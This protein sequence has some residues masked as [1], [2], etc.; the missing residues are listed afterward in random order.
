MTRGMARQAVLA[1]AVLGAASCA[2]RPPGEPMPPPQAAAEAPA[3]AP[4]TGAPIPLTP[5]PAAAAA[6]AAPPPP[7]TATPPAATAAGPAAPPPPMA[8]A[9]P[10][11][12][13]QAAV[14]PAGGGTA[15]WDVFGLFRQ[16]APQR[17]TL[18]NFAFD[19]A[20]V[21]AVVTTNPDCAARDSGVV[22]TSDFA[23]PLNGTR[24]IEAPPGADVCWHRERRDASGW[25]PWN[26]AYLST[27]RS[28]DARL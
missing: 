9:V 3:P 28:I 25:T 27:G 4:Q 15:A 6:R 14:P 17:L 11:P 22:A 5:P 10:P 26:R 12:G 23:L 13:P 18:S 19:R 7:S 21:E 24:I 8:A 16:R 1:A 2:G 20:H